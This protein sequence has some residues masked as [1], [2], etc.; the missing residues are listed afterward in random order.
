VRRRLGRGLR[1]PRKL[2]AA[3]QADQADQA[4][5][6]AV[7]GRLRPR[8]EASGIGGAPRAAAE[9]PLAGGR[10]EEAVSGRPRP[11]RPIGEAAEAE[12]GA[13]GLG[14]ENPTSGLTRLRVS[15]E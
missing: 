11:G 6:E 14:R 5:A 10:G 15:D 1:Y 2:A 4:E 7:S 9:R 12:A 13:G 3:D 8:R